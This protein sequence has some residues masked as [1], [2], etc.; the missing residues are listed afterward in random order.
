MRIFKMEC[1]CLND[2]YQ[3][4]SSHSISNESCKPLHLNCEIK[5]KLFFIFLFVEE[6]INNGNSTQLILNK[7]MLT[8]QDPEGREHLYQAYLNV[9]VCSIDSK[10][11]EILQFDFCCFFI[12]DVWSL[13][14][15]INNPVFYYNI[16]SFSAEWWFGYNIPIKLIILSLKRIHWKLKLWVVWLRNFEGSNLTFDLQRSTQVK[17]IFAVWTLKAHIIIS[18]IVSIDTFYLEVFLRRSTSKSSIDPFCQSHNLFEIL[19]FK[20]FRFDFEFWPTEVTWGQ[21]FFTIRKSIHDLISNFYWHFLSISYRFWDI[22]LQSILE[23]DL[24]LRPLDTTW[25]Q[26]YFHYSKAH[27][28]LPI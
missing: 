20:V 22:W 9:M 2:M 5:H 13:Q 14:L 27:T 6:H 24:D 8:Q 19:D 12:C 15:L 18:C 25:G 3:A 1:E 17:N 10:Y 26:K 4:R 11:Y 7:T 16:C 23:F 28:W 21:H